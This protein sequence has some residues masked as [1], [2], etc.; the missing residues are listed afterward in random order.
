MAVQQ[1]KNYGIQIKYAVQA[2]TRL[3]NAHCVVDVWNGFEYIYMTYAAFM[4]VSFSPKTVCHHHFSFSQMTTDKG[5]D[6]IEKRDKFKI[7]GHMGIALFVRFFFS[8]R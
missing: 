8:G 7:E 1:E 2:F 6:E 5:I 4:L 3:S